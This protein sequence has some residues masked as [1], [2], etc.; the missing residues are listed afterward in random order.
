MNSPRKPDVAHQLS[1]AWPPAWLPIYLI[2]LGF[3][4]A[5]LSS[6]ATT[7][8]VRRVLP[9]ETSFNQE[10]GRGGLI[11]VNIRLASGEELPFI[12]DT[13]APFCLLD[14]SLEPRLGKPFQHYDL[15][16]MF[17]VSPTHLYKSPQLWRCSFSNW[18]HNSHDGL[19]PI[20]EKLE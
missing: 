18:C 20:V 17:G 6:C 15:H 5:L 9:A 10:A 4:L 8:S 3:G 2:S 1:T 12:V 19:Q 7:N 16:S 13:G 11:L 14:K